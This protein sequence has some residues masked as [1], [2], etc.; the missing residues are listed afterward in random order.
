MLHSIS[1]KKKKYYSLSIY[2][3]NNK[4][5]IANNIVCIYTNISTNII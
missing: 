3:L 2:N 5:T 1:V 4:I